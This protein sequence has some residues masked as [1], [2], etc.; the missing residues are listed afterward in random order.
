[1]VHTPTMSFWQNIEGPVWYIYIYGIASIIITCC[2][3][4]KG[5]PLFINQPMGKGPLWY[6]LGSQPSGFVW[7]ILADAVVHERRMRRVKGILDG[8]LSIHQVRTSRSGKFA[9]YCTEVSE[10]SLSPTQNCGLQHGLIPF[11][12]GIAHNLIDINLYIQAP[13]WSKMNYN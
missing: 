6:T 4:G 7:W 11:P 9:L 8:N 1:M 12:N 2:Y 3:R 5:G 10:I 13:K